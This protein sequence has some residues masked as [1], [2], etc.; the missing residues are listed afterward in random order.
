MNSQQKPN[1][2]SNDSSTQSSLTSLPTTRA[3]QFPKLNEIVDPVTME[4]LLPSES[5]E[6]VQPQGL[7]NGLMRGH[8][9]IL[10]Q[11]ILD[12][13]ERYSP[14]A[15]TLVQQIL[16]RQKSL[17]TLAPSERSVLDRATLDFATFVPP[18]VKHERKPPPPK[19]RVRTQ[20]AA[21]E[22][23]VPG[24]DVPVTEMPAYWWLK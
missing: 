12:H 7:F 10:A 19:P 18:S 1:R 23:P 5:P 17:E 11:D 15:L 4:V 22:E 20:V 6:P 8:V 24:V 13:P 16:E 14:E 2:P 21:V 9:E 3:Y